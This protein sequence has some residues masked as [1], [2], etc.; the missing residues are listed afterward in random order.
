MKSIGLVGCGNLGSLIAQGVQNHLSQEYIMA[1]F[2]DPN[3]AAAQRLASRCGG[4]ACQTLAELLAHCPDY[5][6]E[7]AT[8]DALKHIAEPSLRAGCDVIALSVGALADEDFAARIERVTRQTGR[9]LHVAS[10]AIGGFDLMRTA[11]LAGALTCR[12]VNLKSPQA[13]DGADYL[14]D[15]PLSDLEE[16]IFEGSAQEAIAAFPKNVNVAVAAAIASGQHKDQLAEDTRKDHALLMDFFRKR[17]AAG[18]GHAMAIH[19]HHSIDVM[20]LGTQ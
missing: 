4:R 6:V 13:L 12:V 15:H 16:T 10:G 17:D 8:G 19:M 14:K 18:A 2:L 5:I 1:F 11:K 3:E 7:A 20:G 9:K